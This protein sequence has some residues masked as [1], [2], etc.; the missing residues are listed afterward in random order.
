MEQGLDIGALEEKAAEVA[1][2]LRLLANDR[3]LLVLCLLAQEGEMSVGALCDEIG[4]SQ[5]ALSQHLAKLRGEDLVK[6]RRDAQTLYY[7]IADSRVGRLLEAL[8]AIYCA[9]GADQDSAAKA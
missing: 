4:I 8:Y 3:R 5:S 2:V 9:P 6:T 7:S 1:D